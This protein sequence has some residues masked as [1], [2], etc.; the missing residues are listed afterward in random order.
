MCRDHLSKVVVITPVDPADPLRTLAQVRE[1]HLT[2]SLTIHL[3]QGGISRL[4]WTETYKED[5]AAALAR[6]LLLG[7]PLTSP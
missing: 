3:S 6:P 2:G 1:A 4:E 7:T 5:R